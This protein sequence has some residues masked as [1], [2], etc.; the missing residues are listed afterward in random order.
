[1]KAWKLALVTILAALAAFLGTQ[2]CAAV[3]VGVAVI[4]LGPKRLKSLPY[5]VRHEAA[6]HLLAVL[7]SAAG[8][9]V[10]SF[11][12]KLAGTSVFGSMAVI[13][14]W[15]GL[16]TSVLMT[17]FHFESFPVRPVNRH[18]VSHTTVFEEKRLPWAS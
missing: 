8:A 7:V 13:A 9:L 17:V 3:W 5:A 16:G 18:V 15:L 14:G 12:G 4:E 1:M 2:A 11:I 6:A 10:A